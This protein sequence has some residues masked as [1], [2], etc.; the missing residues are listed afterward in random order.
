MNLAGT[1]THKQQ[2]DVYSRS[3]YKRELKTWKQKN[4]NFYDKILMFLYVGFCN[5]LLKLNL[6]LNFNNSKP[7]HHG[8]FEQ[9]DTTLGII[10]GKNMGFLACSYV[11]KQNLRKIFTL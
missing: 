8:R 5:A 11:T 2:G 10:T 4:Q 7:R 9:E 3:H 6:H 1:N